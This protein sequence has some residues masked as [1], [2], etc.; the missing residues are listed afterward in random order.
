MDRAVIDTPVVPWNKRRASGGSPLQ[1]LAASF[2][3]AYRRVLRRRIVLRKRGLL[4]PTSTVGC[5][6]EAED[7]KAL[8]VPLLSI[9]KLP[10]AGARAVSVIPSIEGRPLSGT[11][12]RRWRMRR[13]TGTPGTVPVG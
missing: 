12:T 13:R 2:G 10:R 1:E 6:T 11:Y 5:W 7:R 3:F 8:A 4:G 9:G